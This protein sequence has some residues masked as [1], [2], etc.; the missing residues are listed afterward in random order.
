MCSIMSSANSDGV[1]SSFLIS[2]P[3]ISFSFLTAVA[4]TDNTTLNRLGKS[5][6]LVLFLILKEMPST[7]HC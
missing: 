5:G 3:F 4:Q 1:N 6:I 7:F 2:I